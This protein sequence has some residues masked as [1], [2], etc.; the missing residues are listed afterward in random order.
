MRWIAV[1]LA[2][3]VVA[4]GTEEPTSMSAGGSVHEPLLGELANEGWKDAG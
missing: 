1:G 3:T 4:F 2:L